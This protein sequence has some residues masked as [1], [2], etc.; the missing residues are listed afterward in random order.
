MKQPLFSFYKHFFAVAMLFVSGT[1]WGQVVISQIYGGGGNTGAT[2]KND[3]VELFNRGTTAQSLSGWSVQQAS[4]TGTTW[5]VTALTNVTLQ[6]GQYYLIALASG[7]AVG[8]A[9]PTPDITNTSSNIGVGGG[10]IVLASTTGAY[11]ITNPT[12]NVIDKIGFGS[13]ANGFEGAYGPVHSNTT[14]TARKSGGCIDTDHN[15]N[16]FAVI[17]PTPKNTSSPLN[18]CAVVTNHLVVFDKNDTAATGAMSNQTIAEGASANLTTNGFSYIGYTFEGWAT[19][20]SGAVVYT[21]GASFTMGASDVTLYAKWKVASYSLTYNGNGSTGGTVNSGGSYDY[22]STITLPAATMTRTGYTFAGWNTSANGSG[23]NYSAGSSYTMPAAD[24]TLYAKWTANNYQI[25]F[26]GNGNTGGSMSNQTIA[27]EATA[28]LTANAFSRTGYAFTEWNTAANGSGTAYANSAAYTMSTLGDKTLYAQWQ[29]Y[30]GPCG[31]ESFTNS[32]LTGSYNAS[33]YIGDNS[34]TWTYIESRDQSTYGI[35]GKGIML[36]DLTSRITSSPVAGGI[37]SFTCNLR[38]AFT[39]SGNRQVQLYVNGVAQTPSIAWDNTGVQTYTITNINIAGNIIIEMRNATGNQVIVDDISW[40]CYTPC[41]SPTTQATNFTATN[42]LATTATVNWTR[43]N[44]DG[45]IVLAREGTPV[46]ADPVSGTTYTDNTAFGSGTEIGTGNFVVYNGSGTTVNLT[47]LTSGSTYHFAVYEYNAATH[48]YNL[49]SP[50]TGQITTAKAPETP[51][52]FTKICTTAATQQLSWNAPDGG[53]DGY[54][55]VVRQ[56][57]APHSVNGINAQS[58]PFNLDYT[59]APAFGSTTPNSRI[60]YRGTGTN[61]TIT[62][63]SNNTSYTFALYAYNANGSASVLYSGTTTT[64]QVMGVPD[65]NFPTASGG[66]ATAQISW[67]NPS[68][69]CFDEVMAVVTTAAGITFVPA[70]DGSAYTANAVYS[71]PNQVVHKGGGNSVLISGLTNGTTYYIELFVRNGS[72]WSK[73]EEIAVTPNNT[74]TVFKPGELFFVGYDGQYEG[75]GAND[76]YLIA[77]LVEIKQGTEF[78]F[79]NSRYEAGAAA[80]VR[81]D[82][83]GGSGDF[84]GENPGV[85]RIKYNGS[86]AIAAGSVLRIRTNGTAGFFGSVAVIGTDNVLTDRT[87]DFSA[88]L[89]FGTATVPHISISGF[90]QIYLVQGDFVSDG[91]LQPGEANY[92]LNGTLLHGLTNR[93]PWIPL[94]SANSSGESSKDRTSRLPAMLECFNLEGSASTTISGYYENDKLHS[95]SFR[96]IMSAVNNSANWTYSTDRYSLD[97]DNFISSRAGRSFIRTGG[98]PDG[99]WVSNSDTNW[100]YCANW[101]SLSVPNSNTDVVIGSATVPAII[102]NDALFS[103]LYNDTAEVKSLTITG[104]SVRMDGTKSITLTVYRNLDVTGAGLLD[105]SGVLGNIEIYGNWNTAASADSFKEGFSRV[106]FVGSAPQ[107]INGNDHANPEIFYSVVLNN[108]FDT[109]VSNNLIAKKDLTVNSGKDIRIAPNDY[110]EV[111]GKLVH[112]G[113]ETNFI[114][115]NDGQLLQVDDVQNVGKITVKRNMSLKDDR[116]EYNYLA[117]PVEGQHMKFLFGNAAANTPYVL[118]LKESANLFVNASAADY[119]V[120]GKGFAVKEAVKEY[121][122]SVAYFVGKPVNG[123]WPITITR[124]SAGLGWNLIGNPYASNLDLKN[125]YEQN[126]DNML[127]EF[128]FWDNRVNKTYVQY[129]GAYNGYSYAI[130]NA[131]SDEGNPA[132]G[133]DA[134]NNTGTPGTP[135]KADGL[136]RFAKVGQGFVIRAKNVGSSTLNFSNTQ[137]TVNQPDRG[138]FGKS[139]TQKDR[140]RLQMITPS[141]L[142]LTNTVIYFAEGNTA[143]GL[144]DSRHP[145]SGATEAFYSFAGTDKTVINGRSAFVDTDVLALGNKHHLAGMYR[146]RAIDRIG[147]FGNS[148]SIYLKDKK[149]NTLTDLTQRDYSFTS[150]SGEFTGRFEIIYKPSAVLAAD[151]A[152]V[153]QIEMYRDGSDFVVRSSDR[154]IEAVEVYDASGRLVLTRT[155]NGKELRFTALGLTEG[156]YVLKS[157]L[158]GGETYTKKIRK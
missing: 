59:A 10:K 22:N 110:F 111:G 154:A 19:T 91:D 12:V 137:R 36:R 63:L 85:A 46:N 29:V 140:Y 27:Y 113:T 73:G 37:S 148:Q 14:S 151:S 124:T 75:S 4:A 143:F 157:I 24:T 58:Q 56:G 45:V 98:K 107:V 122:E 61:V 146:I 117:S 66:D 129:G 13:T 32:N 114:I 71:A 144:E 30:T 112:S 131:L 94:S 26:N 77:T 68:S 2:Y 153:A 67:L 93:T 16:D 74:F 156:I 38:K 50:A 138:F 149:L 116:N 130:Y 69:A 51:T 88:S 17:S 136:Y 78:S 65:V 83:W 40:T 82:K 134:G 86:A 55:L 64:T 81:T 87:A 33:S 95:G 20:S 119:T 53:A 34:V 44:G 147:V 72:F 35:N 150:D 118:V 3:F 80:N 101:E 105:L 145:S 155:G 121:T 125:Y 60:V 139:S 43:G 42:I 106:S 104:S 23:T 79:V 128:R 57:A 31:S 126:T 52:A 132:P 152:A 21:N 158:K 89:P 123:S 28:N 5:T 7:G 127:P 92:I 109:S 39:G 133:G 48:C 62:G 6:P 142:H 120:I 54:L 96:D 97:P 41:I 76:E 70:G 90:D 8:S 103:D 102:N 25:N 49:V 9:L 99:T 18:L 47:A 108:H 15:A 11:T 135:A 1:G 115:E 84:A 141:G 100:Y